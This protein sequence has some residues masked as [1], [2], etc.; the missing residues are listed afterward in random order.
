M[1]L[2]AIVFDFDG[3]IAN[4]EPLHLRAFQEVL[5]DERIELTRD[6][7][8]ARYLGY[9]DAGVFRVIGQA[10][11]N[12]FSAA[13][14]AALVARK[15]VRLEALQQDK[16]ILFPGAGDAIRRLAASVPL[17]IASGALGI[18]I[19]RVLDREDLTACFTTIVS[20]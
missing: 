10:R 14:V 5:A 9:D 12:A 13:Q 17:A 1:P 8:Y 11:G 7:Y 15:A 6:E 3:V 16:S 18:E 19:R 2:R 20:A 4:S